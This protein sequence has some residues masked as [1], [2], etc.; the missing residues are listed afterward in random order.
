MFVIKRKV[1]EH[2]VLDCNLYG[3]GTLPYANKSS[4][5]KEYVRA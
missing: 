2:I 1:T 3:N 5:Q 4:P